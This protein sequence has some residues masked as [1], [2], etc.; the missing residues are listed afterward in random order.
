MHSQDAHGRLCLLVR[1][2]AGE[3]VPIFSKT[4][5]SSAVSASELGMFPTHTV[6]LLLVLPIVKL[7]D[8]PCFLQA[9]ERAR[10]SARTHTHDEMQAP[11]E[12]IDGHSNTEQPSALAAGNFRSR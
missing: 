10:K 6:L 4:I 5:R 9:S 12:R 8:T 1:S 2:K 7:I 11:W 3:L